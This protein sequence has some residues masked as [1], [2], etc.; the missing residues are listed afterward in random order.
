MSE[1]SC[2]ASPSLEELAAGM[3]PSQTGRPV[4]R[5][6]RGLGSPMRQPDFRAASGQEDASSD[7]G[8]STP[9][10][11]LAAPAAPASGALF[12]ENNGRLLSNAPQ[13]HPI[14]PCLPACMPGEPQLED[15]MWHASEAGVTPIVANRR[16]EK[17]APLQWDP[18]ALPF[19]PLVRPTPADDCPS[20]EGAAL[21]R[22]PC[23][24]A[25]AAGAAG[26]GA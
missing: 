17:L 20:R 19:Q 7:L 22:K 18:R 5:L 14:D 26:P 23:C 12:D 13:Q 6:Q 3:T 4:P 11:P 24:C 16:I 9:A 25:E 8:M 2:P 1:Q 10:G 21:T 15:F